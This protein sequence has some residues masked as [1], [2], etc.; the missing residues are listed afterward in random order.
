M[1]FSRWLTAAV[2]VVAAD[3]PGIG[4]AQAAS[5]AET[6]GTR[7]LLGG[8]F[9]QESTTLDQWSPSR[10]D[11]ELTDMDGAG[12]KTVIL[13]WTLDEDNNRALYPAPA[14][15]Y[16][17][18]PDYVTPL[19]QSARRHGDSVWLGLAN[20]GA[21]QAHA[22]DYNWMYSQLYI[23]QRVADQLHLGFGGQ[24]VGWYIP[25][26][27]DDKLLSTP[28]AVAN[29][30]WFFG[31]LAD[32]LH[33]HNG[34]LP[35]MASLTYGNLKLSPA[36][37][38]AAAR[39]VLGT[40][41]VLNVQDTGGSGYIGPSDIANWFSALSSALAGTG[42]ALWD[43]ADMF[44]VGGPMPPEQLQANLKAACPY[45]RAITGFSF[46]TQMGPHD[47]GTSHFYDAYNRYRSSTPQCPARQ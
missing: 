20:F 43:D 39:D 18:G 26:E 11:Q 42:V 41:D 46:T 37:L 34:G 38:A 2:L 29:M 10:W 33:A 6:A 7:P 17:R 4:A 12:I 22:S 13:Q 23:M 14:G 24:F 45:V 44:A 36:A 8:S 5:A 28:A 31:A 35:V 9:I 15:W 27:V 21:W 19:L 47:P 32:Y 30:R 1:T 16:P 25:F 3:L 40:V